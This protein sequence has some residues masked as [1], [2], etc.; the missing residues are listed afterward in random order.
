MT[1]V[2]RAR[3]E[4]T[5]GDPALSRVV[6]RLARRLALGRPLESEL[7]LSAVTEAERLALSRL[8]GRK[9]SL[10]GSS[11]RFSP[12]Q[13]STILIRSEIAP[14]LRSAVE[15]L[16][17]PVTSRAEVAAAEDAA[18]SAAVQVLADGRHSGA[19][20]YTEWAERLL[21]DG[22]VTRLVRGGGSD[23][24]RLA[25]AVLDELPAETEPLPALAERVTG[26]TKALAGTRLARL[27]L[28]ALALREVS[29]Q[30]DGGT[31][32]LARV[33]VQRA[34]WEA[35]GVIPDDLASQVL[36][37]GLAA[38]PC[39]PLGRWLAEAAAEGV[40]FRATLQQLVSMPVSPVVGRVFVCEN[41]SVLRA[42]ASAGILAGSGRPL[43]DG[44]G[45]ADGGQGSVALVC[46]EG[47]PSAACHRALT[48]IAS[49]GAGVSWRGDFD[50]T[51]LRTVAAAI[52]RYAAR[53]WRM[54]AADYDA[55]LALGPT[56]RVRGFAADSPWDP[57]LAGRITETGRAVMEERLVP[58]LLA[59]LAQAAS[60][61]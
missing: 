27:V 23:L 14:D 59:D 41:P 37:L 61:D 40:P 32:A 48:S 24:I 15:A 46:T 13:L 10:L 60:A 52:S 12:L 34:L 33:E 57:R 28:R 51:G 30:S 54:S 38:V 50:W 43:A 16:A 31:S 47:N 18:R 8:L 29:A 49:T 11:V 9:V 45:W 4:R 58:L 35:A 2:D 53:P 1:G 7:T 21:L 26:D 55:A 22:T 17:G 25:V 3:L 6:T 5:L 44:A 19:Q 20:W 36:V 39:H 56:A 42:V